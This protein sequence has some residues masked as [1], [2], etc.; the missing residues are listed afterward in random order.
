MA[1]YHTPTTFEDI[2]IIWVPTTLFF[3]IFWDSPPVN[4][5]F[6]TS[7]ILDICAQT[8]FFTPSAPQNISPWLPSSNNTL[9]ASLAPAT[10]LEAGWAST[11]P[12]PGP[13]SLPII[14]THLAAHLLWHST[15]MYST[16]QCSTASHQQIFLSITGSFIQLFKQNYN[17]KVSHHCG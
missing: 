15:V 2:D 3:H 16:G 4:N 1:I 14:A 17:R 11:E 13:Q 10:G 7:I 9:G 8:E 12:E 6:F 5:I